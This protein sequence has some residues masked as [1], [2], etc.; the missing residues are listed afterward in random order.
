MKQ[1]FALFTILALTAG[2][3]AA[4]PAITTVSV[5]FK[6][7]DA[8][9]GAPVEAALSFAGPQAGAARSVDPCQFN[10]PEGDYTV[11]AKA[12]GYFDRAVAISL[13]GRETAV[14]DIALLK[15]GSMMLVDVSWTAPNKAMIKKVRIEGLAGILLNNPKA[16]VSVTAY[17]DRAGGRKMNQKLANDRADAIRAALV[18]ADIDAARV[19]I[20]GRL[21]TVTG[22]TKAQKETNNRVEATFME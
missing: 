2:L 13:A 14:Y 6:P 21:V 3:A 9:T 20:T 19:E 10:L 8:L 11:L 22:K 18:K 17:V 7:A 16:R 1:I 12:P 15:K 4:Q 5:S